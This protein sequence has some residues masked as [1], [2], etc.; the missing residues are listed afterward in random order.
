MK[1]RIHVNQQ[2]LS[3]NRNHKTNK[4][5]IMVVEDSG[6][7]ECYGV[8]ILGPSEVVYDINSGVHAFIE[9]EAEIEII[10]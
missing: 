3:D 9:T 8:K 4:P 6:I 10:K 1:K 5:I 2:N 7:T